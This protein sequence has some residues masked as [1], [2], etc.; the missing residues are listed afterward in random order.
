M[1]PFKPL[2]HTLALFGVLTLLIAT[3]VLVFSAEPNSEENFFPFEGNVGIG[4]TSPTRKLDVSGDTKIGKLEARHYLEI[5]SQEWP[6]IRFTTP[7]HPADMRIGMA[8]ADNSTFG[9][10]NGDMY[11]YSPGVNRM[12]VVVQ[13]AG[14]V[15]LVPKGGNVGI[16]TTRPGYKLDVA[17]DANV[18]KLDARHYLEIASQEWPEI[19]FTTPSQTAGMRIGMA[20]ADNSTYGVADGDMYVYSSSVDRMGV[21]VQRAGDVSLVPKGGKVGIGTTSPSEKLEVVGTVKATAF[22]GDG[23]GLTGIAGGGDGSYD[24]SASSPE[25]A[26]YVND[27]GNVGIGTTSPSE[28]LEV[29]GTVKATAFVGDGS[30]LTG[31]AGGGDGSYDSSASSPEDAVYVNDNGNVGIGTTSPSEKL[32]VVG[33]VKA[34]AF[35]GDGSGLTG[36]AGGGDGSYDSSASSPEDAV[37]VNDNGNVGIGTTSP[38]YKLDVAGDA[39]VGKEDARH[40]LEITSKEWPEIKF[41]TPSQTAGMKI[42]M[43]H[44]DNATYGV[45]D[46]DMYVYSSSLDRMGVVV[47]RAG[48]VSLAPKGGKVGIGTTSPS[49]KLD[50]AGTTKTSDL[51]IKNKTTCGKLYTDTQGAVQCGTDSDSG[52][53]ITGVTAGTGLSGGGDSGGVTL[54]VDKNTIQ[55]RVSSPC[56]AGQSIRAISATGGVTCEVDDGGDASYDSSASS[57]EDAVY[58]NDSGNVGIGTTSPIDAL[59]IETNK[60]GITLKTK[61]PAQSALMR[62]YG[63]N[64]VVETQIEAGRG[65]S[66]TGNVQTYSNH[67]LWF[68]THNTERMRIAANGNVGIGTTSPQFLLHSGAV[69]TDNDIARKPNAKEVALATG[70]GDGQKSSWIWREYWDPTN[71]GIFHDN[72]TDK[73]HTVGNSQAVMTVGLASGNVGIGT[74]NPTAKLQIGDGTDHSVLFISKTNT[75][76]NL[77]VIASYDGKSDIGDQTGM[78]GYGVR[79]TDDAWQIQE[80]GYHGGWTNLFTVKN[81]GNVGIGT[82]SPN[83]KLQLANNVAS[84]ALDTYGEYQMILFDTGTPSTSY[85]FGIRSN[86]FVLQSD[87]NFHFDQDGAT[88]MAINSGNV[89][90]GTTSPGYK[91]DVAG[92]ANV[93]KKDA[94]HYL[95]ITSKDWPEIRFTTPSHT[96][97]MRIGMA[98]YDNSTYGVTNGD[99]YVYSHGV[100]RM[101]VVVQRAGDVSLVPKGGNVGI[102]T[103]SPNA[104]LEIEA[105]FPYVTPLLK[106]HYPT[107]SWSSP[108]YANNFRFIETSMVGDGHLQ[109]KSFS[110]N[111]FGIGIGYNPPTWGS[112]NALL[113]NGNVGIGTTAPTAKL[114]ILDNTGNGSSNFGGGTSLLSLRGSLANFSEP[115][116]EFAE[117]NL[118]PIASVAAKNRFGGSGDL[119]FSTRT[120]G[121]GVL[122]ERVR[123]RDDGNVGI[124]TTNPEYKLEVNGTAG[125]TG[126]GAWINPSDSRLKDIKGKFPKGLTEIL[127]L[128]PIEFKYKL[129]NPRGLPSDTNEIGFIAQEV[130]KVFPEAVTEG[131]DGYLDLNVHAINIAVINAVQELSQEYDE[132]LKE[133]QKFKGENSKLQESNDKLQARI[134]ALEAKLQ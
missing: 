42:G 68:G 75:S 104:K 122:E 74:T 108:N 80:N 52:G 58:V 62:L 30:G 130:Q 29:V 72:T 47:Q 77:D 94:R 112:E 124:G 111:G 99:M 50:V 48:D 16:G 115:A 46:G 37:Y 2:Q 55:Q 95:E 31:I 100:N 26:V 87:N 34:T 109:Q 38:G 89:G 127:K 18:G 8:H 35:V 49:E 53:D 22:V 57:P 60:A 54:N 98:H 131:K 28:K 63:K 25:D 125:K 91:L 67:P 101:G 134:E 76:P 84:G 1:N 13:R 118:A 92:D 114:D 90:I 66:D 79:P 6:E 20:H 10:T 78:F 21:V 82:A 4:T 27:N 3:S 5:A 45:A 128:N 56:P 65:G 117:Q 105:G 41:T 81:N 64:G 59:N 39:N 7:S 23:S 11:V 133:V 120:I 129:N 126:G 40:Y 71:W 69:A 14:D 93:G 12:G 106:M 24:S 36:I 43:A 19:K 83:A 9:V 107:N 32:E 73:L 119:I 88:K 86:T 51:T 70:N 33:T 110:V 132:L 113:I 116:I 103:T 102:G 123:I 61:D 85:G 97:G 17:G 121:E 15:S 96:A 44:A